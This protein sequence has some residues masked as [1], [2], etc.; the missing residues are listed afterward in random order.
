MI[1]SFVERKF[2]CA[3]GFLFRSLMLSGKACHCSERKMCVRTSQREPLTPG[4]IRGT[5]MDGEPRKS[6]LFQKDGDPYFILR[7][8]NIC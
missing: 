4:G 8:L 6:S 7:K 2:F 1:L 3:G 5:L